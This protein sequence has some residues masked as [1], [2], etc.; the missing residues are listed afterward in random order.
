MS[1]ARDFAVETLLRKQAEAIQLYAEVRR[2]EEKEKSEPT[3]GFFA[4]NEVAQERKRELQVKQQ[5]L[6]AVFAALVK[7]WERFGV[8]DYQGAVLAFMEEPA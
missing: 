4:T 1:Q 3:E 6:E 2:A 8:G 5:R 7:G